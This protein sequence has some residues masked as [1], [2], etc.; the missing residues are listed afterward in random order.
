VTCGFESR[1]RD[2]D[3]VVVA[4]LCG[5]EEEQSLT[6]LVVEASEKLAEREQ[7]GCFENCATG[8]FLRR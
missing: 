3:W 8:K 5:S 2:F 7:P 4:C 6:Q 1:D